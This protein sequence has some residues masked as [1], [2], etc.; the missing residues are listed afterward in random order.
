MPE[1]FVLDTM[2]YPQMPSGVGI[3]VAVDV[4]VG[5]DVP[6]AVAVAVGPESVGV[7]VGVSVGADVAVAVGVSVGA[8][9]FVAVG[10]LVCVGVSVGVFVAVGV[11][12]GVGVGIDGSRKMM[13]RNAL[14]TVAGQPKAVALRIHSALS[15]AE[16]KVSTGKATKTTLKF[17]PATV[18]ET[19]VNPLTAPFE[20]RQAGSPGLSTSTWSS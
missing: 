12:V 14:C 13:G 5:V 11:F 15:A 8:L 17:L 16:P 19:A 4:G 18:V 3:G 2:T 9:V 7:A 20:S 1:V 10:V 6:V